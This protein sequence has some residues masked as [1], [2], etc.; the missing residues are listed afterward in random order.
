MKLS[1]SVVAV[2]I[3]LAGGVA[4]SKA[5]ILHGSDVIAADLLTINTSTGA[6]TSVG[7]LGFVDVQGLAFDR[8][9]NTL[10][11]S[12]I[13]T[14]EL[15]TI[16]TSTGAATSVGLLGFGLV[17]ALAFDPNTNTLYGFDNNTDTLLTINTS[18][19]AGTSV[20][21]LGFGNVHGLTIPEPSTVMLAAMGLVGL[22]AFGWRR[23]KR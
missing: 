17:T 19:G 10:Y 14:D 5:G 4:Q 13:Q 8:N 18:T 20:G 9:T 7:A 1:R 12:T 11:G 21:A 15:L 3:L 6:G 2:L 16:N 22:A 23:R